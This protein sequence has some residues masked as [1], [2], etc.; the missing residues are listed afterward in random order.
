MNP[1]PGL[2]EREQLGAH[3]MGGQLR[4]LEP[5][6]QL[7][8][9]VVRIVVQELLEIEHV[10]SQPGERNRLDH[11]AHAPLTGLRPGVDSGVAAEDDFLAGI[12]DT[13]PELLQ[14]LDIR[15]AGRPSKQDPRARQN[16]HPDHPWAYVA[17][18]IRTSP[19][20]AVLATKRPSRLNR[21][22][23]A[24]PRAPEALGLSVAYNSHS[25]TR[26][27]RWNHIA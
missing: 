2:G 3:S 18:L 11:R 24:K 20:W 4:R 19:S 5:D 15:A 6:Q 27:G 17:F 25:S 13:R 16:D 1:R 7:A 21:P 12:A 10:C 23:R 8:P 9:Q 26:S 14:Y 22:A